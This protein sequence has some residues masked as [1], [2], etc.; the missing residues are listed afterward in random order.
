MVSIIAMS[1]LE[2]SLPPKA[3]TE[4]Y[5]QERHNTDKLAVYTLVDLA[6]NGIRGLIKSLENNDDK[7]RG[8]CCPAPKYDFD[9]GSLHEVYDY[10]LKFAT[11]NSLHPTL[12]IVAHN[13]DYEKKGVLLVNLDTDMKCSVDTCRMKVAEALSAGVNLQ[14]ANMDWEDFKEDELPSTPANNVGERNSA[15]VS[16][17]ESQQPAQP[18]A[19]HHIFGVYTTA[20]TNMT[21]IRG[22]LE[23]DWSDKPPKAWLCESVGSYTDYPDPWTRLIKYHP[24][25]C[26]RN[27]RLHRQWCICADEKDA[28]EH[29]VLLVHIDWDG[30]VDRDPDELLKVGLEV[31]VKT[32]RS[33]VTSAVANLTTLIAERGSRVS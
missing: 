12:F 21:D 10:H 5:Q 3:P 18:S 4:S 29:G 14:I 20:G 1:T 24:W 19:P 27:P 2:L 6:N 16:H 28:K 25:N 11:E 8:A 9:G 15:Q 32:K 23:P 7:L 30:N 31:D 22:L 33:S 26:R 17:F 13:Q